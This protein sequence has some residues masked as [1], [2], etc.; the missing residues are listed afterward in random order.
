M[1]NAT[2]MPLERI[3]VGINSDRARHTQTPGP[4]AK[5][6]T[7]AYRAMATSQPWLVSGTRPI[8]A[9]SIVSGAVRAISKLANGFLKKA[10]ILFA[11]TQ[12]ARV[13]RIGAAAGSSERTKLLAALKSP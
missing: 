13:I 9:L 8:T 2:L 12:L 11:G 4:S 5:N 10:S 7:N 3:R 1:T 6:A